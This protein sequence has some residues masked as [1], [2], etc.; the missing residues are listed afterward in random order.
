MVG[1]GGM[2]NVE[3]LRSVENKWRMQRISFCKKGFARSLFIWTITW[4]HQAHESCSEPGSSLVFSVLCQ[5]RQFICTEQITTCLTKTLSSTK[6]HCW[7]LEGRLFAL[8][9]VALSGDA[10][11]ECGLTAATTQLLSKTVQLP[12]AFGA[13]ICFPIESRYWFCKRKRQ[14]IY[15]YRYL[16]V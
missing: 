13:H 6:A 3:D 7:E 14:Y 15:I 5:A 9:A 2:T 4:P 8:Q 10:W 11:V 16:H 12:S 1:G